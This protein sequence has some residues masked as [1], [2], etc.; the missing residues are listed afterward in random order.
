MLERVH[1]KLADGSICH[2]FNRNEDWSVPDPS[3]VWELRELI[4]VFKIVVTT[5]CWPAPLPAYICQVLARR[6]YWEIEK[7][8]HRSRSTGNVYLN[9]F[10]NQRKTW[11]QPILSG[12]LPTDGSLKKSTFW[13]WEIGYFC[14]IHIFK[15]VI[16]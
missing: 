5:Y 11:C 15:T 12:F 6:K 16:I 8:Q 3:Q 10:S 13:T 9:D 1:N 14:N 7:T 4:W 2:T